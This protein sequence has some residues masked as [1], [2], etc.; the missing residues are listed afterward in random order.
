MTTVDEKEI[1]EIEEI[2]ASV[3][4]MKKEVQ[5]MSR[6]ELLIFGAVCIALGGLLT[7]AIGS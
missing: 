4:K 3:L 1:L 7:K 2:K 6:K 5:H